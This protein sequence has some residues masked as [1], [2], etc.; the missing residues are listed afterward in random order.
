MKARPRSGF[1]SA[2]HENFDAEK[3]FSGKPVPARVRWWDRIERIEITVELFGFL[4]SYLLD[5]LLNL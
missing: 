1:M 5:G 2:T 3:S 4:L